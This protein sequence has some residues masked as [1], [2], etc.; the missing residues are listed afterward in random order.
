[1][2]RVPDV[3]AGELTREQKRISE[4]IASVR[5]GYVRGPFAI[6]IRIPE[7]ADTANKLGNALRLHGKLDRRLLELTIAIVARDWSAQYEWFAHMKRGLA[8]GLPQDLYESLR[9][10]RI[11]QFASEDE[12]IVYEVVNELIHTKTLSQASY[13]RALREFGLEGVIE[14]VTDVGFYTMI[15]MVLN[16]FDVSIPES[17]R[18]GRELLS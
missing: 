7:I 1:M 6:W 9:A 18:A 11:P 10:G 3:E 14:L 8:A 16:A 13:D 2:T 5:G 17:V 15:A 12:K 4:E